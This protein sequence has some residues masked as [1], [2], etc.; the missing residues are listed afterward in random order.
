MGEAL[1]NDDYGRLR[2]YILG[3][4]KATAAEKLKVALGKLIDEKYDG[5][6]AMLVYLG[7]DIEDYCTELGCGIRQ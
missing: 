1:E 2:A 5:N 4:G 3:D 6:E 7:A